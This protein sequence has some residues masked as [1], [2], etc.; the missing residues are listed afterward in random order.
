MADKNQQ[1]TPETRQQPE[2]QQQ[3]RDKDRW[4][5]GN[6]TAA[7]NFREGEE[8]FVRDNRD[9]IPEL[10]RSAKTALDGKE[11]EALRKAESDARGHSHAKGE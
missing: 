7:E 4:G 2:Q 11:G 9:R 10:G 5:E 8:K 3:N 6:Y 1:Q